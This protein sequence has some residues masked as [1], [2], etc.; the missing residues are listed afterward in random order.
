MRPSTLLRTLSVCIPVRLLSAP[1]APSPVRSSF[2][3][4][5]SSEID[6]LRCH[7]QGSNSY[8]DASWV[9]NA[10]EV[11]SSTQKMTI[12]SLA[13]IVYREEDRK[14]IE[15]YVEG[16]VEL[17][18]A[19]N[20]LRERMETIKNY[21]ESLRL[22]THC[23]QGRSEPTESVLVRAR[24][25]I[26]SCES[27]ELEK[28]SSGVLRKL[29]GPSSS[30]Y[31]TELHEVLSGSKAIALLVCGMLEI[32][33]SF[34]SKRGLPA[35]QNRDI[36]SWSSSLHELHKEVKEEVEKRRKSGDAVLTELRETVVATRSLRDLMKN[37]MKQQNDQ[38]RV[39]VDALDRSCRVL[40]EGIKPL[41]GRL[42]EL[43]KHLI[44]IRMALL[45]ILSQL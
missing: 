13:N 22:V 16:I 42:N 40:E 44:S 18:D 14:L 17:L 34:K 1:V 19:C 26:N 28:C 38:V 37:K 33:L 25:V 5:F 32:V 7:G 30:I 15:D 9:F 4:W 43:Y 8:A 10:L 3:R 21:I 45:G 23:F 11:A 39:N 12:Q 27:T 36:S 31:G 29:D 35:M 41:E 6:T 20:K 2:D 24:V